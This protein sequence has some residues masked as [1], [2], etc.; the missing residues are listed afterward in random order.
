MKFIHLSILAAL[1]IVMAACQNSPS[2]ENQAGETAE[3]RS[4]S[5]EAFYREKMLLTPGEYMLQVRLVDVSK[6]DTKSLLVAQSNQPLH[7]T[8]PFP[9]ELSY[10]AQDIKEGHSYSVQ[11][12][13]T[14]NG[15]LRF[16]SDQAVNPFTEANKNP[17]ILLKAVGVSAGKQASK[18]EDATLSNNYWK[19]VSVNGK[20]VEKAEHQQEAHIQF[21]DD[22]TVNGF[23]FCNAFNGKYQR[24]GNKLTFSPLASTSKMC[25]KN[26]DSELSFA[27]A[28]NNT[29]SYAIAADALK[30]M[31]ENGNGLA[32][33]KRLAYSKA[34]K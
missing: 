17:S 3:K 16:I 4:I 26:M 11:A 33:F 22:G 27:N 6:Q 10:N 13:I 32:I 31:D 15:K 12:R 24:D 14:R 19:L 25:V 8:P 5:G 21:N 29:K 7:G 30:L 20:A 1:S 28:L 23:F 2:A 18:V 34:K 9:F